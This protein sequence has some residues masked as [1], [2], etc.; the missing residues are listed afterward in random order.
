[1]SNTDDRSR[2]RGTENF[3]PDLAICIHMHLTGATW[4][5]WWGE[6][7]AEYELGENKRRNNQ[8]QQTPRTVLKRC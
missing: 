6:K 3:Q 5:E 8:R 2:Q 4:V 1:M 7:L